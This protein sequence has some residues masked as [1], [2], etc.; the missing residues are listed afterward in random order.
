MF[1]FYVIHKNK[2]QKQE[3]VFIDKYTL[4]KITYIQTNIYI[5]NE[6]GFFPQKP[7]WK[8]S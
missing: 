1:D 2:S 6:V 3:K 5:Y 7:P 8:L 4:L